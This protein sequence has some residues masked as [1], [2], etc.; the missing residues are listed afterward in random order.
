MR[1]YLRFTENIEQDM[2]KGFSY[3]KTPTMKKAQKL[4]G[5]CAFS[6]DTTIFDIEL[7][8]DREKTKEEIIKDIYQILDNSWYIKSNTAVIIEGEYLGSN[9]NGEGVIIK[10][11]SIYKKFYI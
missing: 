7:G 1:T 10:A 11:N 3:L 9:P 8:C 6:F 2:K 4:Q 5:L